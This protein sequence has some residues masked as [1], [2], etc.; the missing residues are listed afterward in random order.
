[1]RKTNYIPPNVLP[2]PLQL[3]SPILKKKWARELILLPSTISGKRFSNKI[4]DYGIFRPSLISHL[5]QLSIYVR[6]I[7]NSKEWY[8]DIAGMTHSRTCEKEPHPYKEGYT[9]KCCYM[10]SIDHEEC[11][12]FVEEY[13]ENGK[14][15]IPSGM[16]F[17]HFA[18]EL[19]G[20]TL[21]DTFNFAEQSK[22]KGY[23]KCYGPVRHN[24]MP[25][26]GDGE[27]G[28]NVAV[29]Y[30]DPDYNMIE[31]CTAMD[32]IEKSNS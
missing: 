23:T 26:I 1:M 20:N 18:F 16:S 12:V 29:Y 27:T 15:S 5:D 14:I 17:F 32:T 31:F 21:K 22:Q 25:P 28:G 19:K 24:D 8:E 7:E 9:I 2:R 4:N 13:D 10:S 30:Y 6:S 11:L 3:I